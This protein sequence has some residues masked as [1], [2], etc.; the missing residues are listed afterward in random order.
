MNKLPQNDQE[1]P[2]EGPMHD[3]KVGDTVWMLD[4]YG[5][6]CSQTDLMRPF[7]VK[8]EGLCQA[9]PDRALVSCTMYYKATEYVEHHI[10]NRNHFFPSKKKAMD[11]KK[12]LITANPGDLVMYI[13]N[14]NDSNMSYCS[15]TAFGVCVTSDDKRITMVTESGIEKIYKNDCIVVSRLPEVKN[16]VTV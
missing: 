16:G 14:K 2:D 5:N 4:F 1:T 6:Q 15:V 9:S 7:K 11:Y 12:S 3:Y 13:S 10:V 8:I